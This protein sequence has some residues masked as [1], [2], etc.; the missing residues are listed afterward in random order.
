MNM[1]NKAFIFAFWGILISC[2]QS[3]TNHDI[4][5]IDSSQAIDS[6]KLA[7]AKDTNVVVSFLKYYKSGLL[8]PGKYKTYNAQIV[9]NGELSVDKIQELSIIEKSKNKHPHIS[10]ED[11]CK[12]SNYLKIVYSSDTLIVF[13]NN[14]LE[15]TSEYKELKLTSDTIALLLANN[16]T[17]EAADDD[18]LTGCDDFSYIV[19]ESS[20]DEY[21]LIYKITHD[22]GMNEYIKN[23][24][25]SGDT[26]KLNIQIGYQEGTGSYNLNIF[27]ESEWTYFESD[28]QRKFE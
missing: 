17:M 26:V 18:G 9:S 25:I 22:E 13:G 8:L 5:V 2:N 23:I 6:N 1:F 19:V 10:G 12:W 3:V 11:Y 27:R 15:I 14:V 24:N 21:E 16:F 20:S 4:S 28:R 7:G